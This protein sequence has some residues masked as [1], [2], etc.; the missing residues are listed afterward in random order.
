M[1]M[2]QLGKEDGCVDPK[3]RISIEPEE[4][5]LNDLTTSLGRRTNLGASEPII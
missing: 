1:V 5:Q 4:G 2:S 3:Y